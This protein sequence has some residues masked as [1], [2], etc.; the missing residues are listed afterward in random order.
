VCI[1]N[2]HLPPGVNSKLLKV[3]ANPAGP[4]HR[5]ASDV[6][7]RGVDTRR[8]SGDLPGRANGYDRSPTKRVWP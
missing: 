1:V 5:Q 6:L 2:D 3:L 7:E 4:P 8:R